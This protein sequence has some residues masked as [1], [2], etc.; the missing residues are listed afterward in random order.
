MTTELHDAISTVSS[1]WRLLVA[2]LP[3]ELRLRADVQRVDAAM[4]ELAVAL[5]PP[6]DAEV[7]AD[8]AAVIAAKLAELG[9]LQPP[10]QMRRTTLDGEPGR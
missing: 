8:R 5:R 7:R 6:L 3:K 1:C 4:R 10:W 9:D 2:D